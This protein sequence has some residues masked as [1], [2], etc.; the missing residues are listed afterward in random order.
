[1]VT[2]IITWKT[3]LSSRKTEG[4]ICVIIIPELWEMIE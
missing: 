4:I 1:M 2:K 3:V